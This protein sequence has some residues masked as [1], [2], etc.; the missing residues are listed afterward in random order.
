LRSWPVF[1]PSR[2]LPGLA[3][4]VDQTTI[5]LGQNSRDLRAISAEVTQ[6]SGQMG[7]SSTQ[8]RLFSGGP[9]RIRT[10]LTDG[11]RILTIWRG[12]IHGL[13][14]AIGASLFVLTLEDGALVDGRWVAEGE[15]LRG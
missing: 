10:M 9:D 13:L 7:D 12:I 15:G 6:I 8:R 5:A 14:L 11:T 2:A 3:T 1:A 4:Q